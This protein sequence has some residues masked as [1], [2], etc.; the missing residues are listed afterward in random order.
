[1]KSRHDVQKGFLPRFPVAIFDLSR[2]YEDAGLQ[3]LNCASLNIA[4]GIHTVQTKL[5]IES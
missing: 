1:M 4:L 5:S 3:T 2:F